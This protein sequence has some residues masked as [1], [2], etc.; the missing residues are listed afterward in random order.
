MSGAMTRA[1]GSAHTETKTGNTTPTGST[2]IAS[3]ASTTCRSS[4]A[5]GN[6]TGTLRV[7]GRPTIQ[8]SATWDFDDLRF[9]R[10]SGRRFRPLPAAGREHPSAN[11]DGV[12]F[13]SFGKWRGA[14]ARYRHRMEHSVHVRSD[15]RAQGIGQ[16]L[17]AALFPRALAMDKHGGST[18]RTRRPFDSIKTRLRTGGVV[19]RGRPQIRPLARPGL[20]SA[21]PRSVGAAH[22]GD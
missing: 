15:H 9:R 6:I 21:V 7:R 13:S 18:P 2:S 20:C 22:P 16:A 14:W 8:A 17:V 1:A 19:S 11:P 10:P 4:K 5:S 12:G 3:P